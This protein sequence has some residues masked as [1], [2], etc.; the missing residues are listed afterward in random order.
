M[1]GVNMEDIRQMKK[2]H[3]MNKVKNETYLKAFDKLQAVKFLHSKVE[4][5]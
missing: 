3:F 4:T 2:S 1:E 5:V